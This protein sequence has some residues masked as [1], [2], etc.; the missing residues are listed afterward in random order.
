MMSM[1]AI[2]SLIEFSEEAPLI[3]GRFALLCSNVF[4]EE[5]LGP[6]L[7]EHAG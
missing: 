5:V 3:S 1:E 4:L 7:G 2:L 6:F